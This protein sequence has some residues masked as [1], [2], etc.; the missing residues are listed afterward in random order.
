MKRISL[1]GHFRAFTGRI[2]IDTCCLGRL[3]A[4]LGIVVVRSCC[5]TRL[6]IGILRTGLML[7][8]LRVRRCGRTR[9]TRWSR[10]TVGIG[11]WISLIVIERIPAAIP[12]KRTNPFAERRRFQL[13]EQR[14]ASLRRMIGLQSDAWSRYSQKDILYLSDYSGTAWA[15][16]LR[17]C[18]VLREEARWRWRKQLAKLVDSNHRVLPLRKK[19]HPLL[20]MT[21]SR[22]GQVSI[23]EMRGTSRTLIWKRVLKRGSLKGKKVSYGSLAA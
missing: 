10:T 22:T 20:T 15:T 23:Q 9:R 4:I 16:Y 18:Q 19:I 2:S 6:P 14:F 3:E 13:G 1:S 17:P 5:R 8:V 11:C 7:R 12:T 21:R